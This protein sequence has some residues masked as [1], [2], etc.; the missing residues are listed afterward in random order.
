M[1]IFERQSTIRLQSPLKI[2]GKGTNSILPIDK[3]Q[4]GESELYS[5]QEKGCG[6]SSVLSSDSNQNNNISG[7]VE[8]SSYNERRLLAELI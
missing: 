2:T 1:N 4:K 5:Y 6:A 7:E 3:V 8:L